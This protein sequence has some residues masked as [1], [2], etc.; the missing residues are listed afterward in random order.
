MFCKIIIS[1]RIGKIVPV[2]AKATETTKNL[3]MKRKFLEHLSNYSNTMGATNGAG[4][5]YPSGA[6]KFIPGF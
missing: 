1:H 2:L 6:P 3:I 5:A 4:T